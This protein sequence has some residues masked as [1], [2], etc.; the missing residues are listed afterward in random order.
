VSIL[1][2]ARV[3]K[4]PPTRPDADALML[5]APSKLRRRPVAL[6]A[7]VAA[8]ILG[9]VLSLWA[10]SATSA[11]TEVLAVRTV[12]HRGEVITRDD[13]MVVRLGLDPA[14]K[15][16]AA[17]RI[18]QV[19]GQRAALDL[20]AGGLLA[21]DDLASAV[22]PAT[23]M[24]VVGIA[25]AAGMMPAEPLNPGDAVRLVQT[26]GQQGEVTGSPVT[27]TASV[28]EVQAA[29]TADLTIVDV[30]VPSDVAADL[31]ARAATGKVALVLDS[32]ER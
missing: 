11:T 4:R 19:A 12:V 23:G 32:R 16:V 31:A 21:P 7:S 2:K 5:G 17:S 1:T 10:W 6:V 25:L 27:V 28:V 18:D 3:E 24:S 20:A 8:V 30:L 22:V 14:V 26:P 13:L 15:A 29:K 9:A